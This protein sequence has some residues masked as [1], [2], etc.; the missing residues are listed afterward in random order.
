MEALIQQHVKQLLEP[1]MAEMAKIKSELD[2]MKAW[3]RGL[4]RGGATSIG[5]TAGG[6]ET[7]AVARPASLL[8]ISK[9]L[10]GRILLK[11]PNKKG[12]TPFAVG[13]KMVFDDEVTDG[14]LANLGISTQLVNASIEAVLTARA[15]TADCKETFTELM[16]RRKLPPYLINLLVDD[17]LKKGITFEEG[18]THV[19]EVKGRFACAVQRRRNDAM[20]PGEKRYRK[21]RRYFPTEDSALGVCCPNSRARFSPV[22]ADPRTTLS[23]VP[24]RNTLQRT[25]TPFPRQRRRRHPRASMPSAW[26]SSSA[27]RGAAAGGRRRMAA[28][29]RRGAR[30]GRWTTAPACAYLSASCESAAWRAVRPSTQKSHTPTIKCANVEHVEKMPRQ[31][32]IN[33]LSECDN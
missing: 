6:G 1:A 17:L 11:R 15:T 32:S 12:E 31:D 14:A 27:R 28:R 4:S 2:S 8:T 10:E 7:A 33:K 9:E 22:S 24:P 26:W 3:R 30:W 13:V 18:C 20:E 23:F 19:K 21:R 25:S 16:A 5:A 29:A